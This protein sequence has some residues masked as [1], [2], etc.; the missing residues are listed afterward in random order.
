MTA[1]IVHG[2]GS[3]SGMKQDLLNSG[4]TLLSGY[5]IIPFVPSERFSH[6][7]AFLLLLNSSKMAAVDMNSG[8]FYPPPPRLLGQ[9]APGLRK[10]YRTIG[11]INCSNATTN[12]SLQPLSTKGMNLA[13]KTRRIK[14]I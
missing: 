5:H 10:H 7:E 3:S 1:W 8:H 11:W 13:F 6:F 14:K 4:S 2:K 12:S 9:P